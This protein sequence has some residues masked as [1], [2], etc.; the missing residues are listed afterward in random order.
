HLKI[1]HG[2]Q[3]LASH[4]LMISKEKFCAR[5]L[6]CEARPFTGGIVR[7]HQRMQHSGTVWITAPWSCGGIW[8]P[9]TLLGERIARQSDAPRT[10]P[11]GRRGIVPGLPVDRVAAN[12]SLR[13][14]LKFVPC[15]HPGGQSS[16]LRRRLP[17]TLTSSEETGDAVFAGQKA[18]KALYERV[19]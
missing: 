11:A 3:Q 5:K 12:P 7:M 9:A 16:Q 17:A 1:G 6:R 4:H 15:E 8:Q 13:H 10:A 19:G 2:G 18:G 14:F